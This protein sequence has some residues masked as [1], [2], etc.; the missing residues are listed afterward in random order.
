ML[1]VASFCAMMTGVF[2]GNQF[3]SMMIGEINRKRDERN[4]ISYFGFTFP[5]L[6][7][8]IEGYRKLYPTG[9]LHKYLFACL[10]LGFVGWIGFCVALRI[11]G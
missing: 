5:K 1:G 8:I 11:F 4:L 7:A 6:L 10:G 2:A 3:V 9:Q